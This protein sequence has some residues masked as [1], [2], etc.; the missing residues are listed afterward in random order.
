MTD[1][2]NRQAPGRHR[3]PRK[4][5]QFFCLHKNLSCGYSRQCKGDHVC[6]DCGWTGAA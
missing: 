6:P 4:L 5:R 3:A 1:T 2:A